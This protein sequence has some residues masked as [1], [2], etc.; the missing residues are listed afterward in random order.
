MKKV[1]SNEELKEKIY[2]AVDMLCPTVKSTL[3]PC[4]NNVIIDHSSFTPFITNDGVTI[5]ENIESDDV[6]VNTILS[7]IKEASIKTN[8][9]V[10]D[11]TTTTIVLLESL[12]KEGL[13]RIENGINPI[14]LKKEFDSVLYDVENMIINMS[15]SA[16]KNDLLNI[17]INSSNSQEI[18]KLI[19]E[20]YGK[21]GC[22][23]GIDI[24]TSDNI[25]DS[26]EYK[27]GYII[28]SNLASNY[29]FKNESNIN[30]SNSYILLIDN[31][32]YD[33]SSL[34]DILN[35]IIKNNHELTIIAD[36]F[37]EEC[38]NEIMNLYLNENIK[39]YLTKNPEFGQNKFKLLKDLECITNSTIVTNLDYINLNFLGC[40]DKMC[41]N[42]EIITFK[43]EKNS[44][45][46]K[47]LKEIGLENDTDYKTKRIAMFKNG[48]ATIKVGGKTTTEIR[49]R[50]M[51]FDDALC[52][53]NEANKG[54]SIGAG[55]TLLKLSNKL[56]CNN[57]AMKIIK[58]SIKEP[59]KQIIRNAGLNDKEIL[60]KITNSNYE[61]LFNISKNKYENI[62][63][64]TIIDPTSVIINSLKNAC[65]IASML[66]ST[67]SLVINEH[68]NTLNK[69]DDY[70]NI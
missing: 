23:N 67:N 1:I 59:F 64:T 19:S 14:I 20:V 36:D 28:D 39:I 11:G 50:K 18:G 70:N 5:A 51:R 54:I 30:V 33:I 46:K 56:D 58:E 65:S 55:I 40:V 38:I 2:E 35:F 34:T 32:L 66:L 13:K 48:L 29:Y 61:M 49:E 4:G 17:A 21:I 16:T 44:N 63:K 24:I 42:N 68:I 41:I 53:I 37:S 22:K 27:N 60:T 52:A 31:I 3:G 15:K 25:F 6:C 9:T 43:F 62:N 12:Y 69:I 8:E 10:G 45:I 57:D 47:R 7:F 26:V